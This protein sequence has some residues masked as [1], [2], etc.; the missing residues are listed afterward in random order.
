MKINEKVKKSLVL[1]SLLL[2]SM[3]LLFLFSAKNSSQSSTNSSLQSFFVSFPF[4]LPEKSKPTPSPVPNP[5][6]ILFGGDMMF[7]RD[8]R[9]KMQLHGV[10]YI[11]DEL[12]ETFHTYDVVAANLEGPV[13]THESLSVGSKIGS[14]KNYI[15]TFDPSIL[16]MLSENNISIL[17]IGNNHV[18]NFG[19]EGIIETK[20]YIAQNNLHWFG[21]TGTEESSRDRIYMYKTPNHKIAFVSHN[22]F[23]PNG[24]VTA[25]EDV[26]FATEYSDIVIVM[27]HWGNEYQENA[28][29][30][31][32]NQAHELIDTG[33]DLII[34]SHPH[35]V[36]QSE[37][38][39]GKKIYYSLGNFVFD[40]YFSPEVKQ[41]LL[42]GVTIM[43]DSSMQF[44]EIPIHMKYSGKTTL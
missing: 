41:G 7:D 16:P 26:K 5:D 13:T 24:Y 39:N 3:F 17:N 20:Q 15:F 30:V 34:G 14:T 37:E 4:S 12:T 21:N 29:G 8:I 27:T 31:I 28:Q 10:G 2:S 11:L 18:E 32:V 40:Q 1:L 42:V 23:T 38:Y 22:Q 6:T 43:P 25:L 33:A 9:V 35:V 19:T 36:Q 44:I